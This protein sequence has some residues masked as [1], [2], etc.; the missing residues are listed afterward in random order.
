MPVLLKSCWYL[1]KGI[2]CRSNQLI[3]WV[4]SAQSAKSSWRGVWVKAFPVL[5]FFLVCHFLIFFTCKFLWK[6]ESALLLHRKPLCD[7]FQ[8]H[9]MEGPCAVSF[10]KFTPEKG[11]RWKKRSQD[12]WIPGHGQYGLGDRIFLPPYARWQIFCRVPTAR[13]L[14][15]SACCCPQGPATVLLLAGVQDYS[16][17]PFPI[18]TTFLWTAEKS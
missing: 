2:L 7:S 16:K 17:D 9:P 10:L 13:T 4:P 18:E 1:K 5:I 14:P 15:W 12:S 8:I 11:W 3:T 6:C